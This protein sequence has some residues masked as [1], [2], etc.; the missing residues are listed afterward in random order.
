MDIY[1]EVILDHYQNPRNY[2]RLKGARAQNLENPS[3]GDTITM[4]ICVTDD[5]IT[6]IAF[7]GKGCAI[8]QASASL[9]TEHVRGKNVREV[10][11]MGKDVILELVGVELSPARL[12]CAMLGLETLQR[13]LI[14]TNDTNKHTNATNA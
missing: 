12:K 11:K 10:Q 1:Q 14:D 2:G 9:L 6:D 13:V 3:C 5:I 4:S 7:E 8:S